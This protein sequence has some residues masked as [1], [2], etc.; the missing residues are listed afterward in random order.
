MDAYDCGNLSQN[1]G[2]HEAQFNEIVRLDCE[3][4]ALINMVEEP[5][6]FKVLYHFKGTIWNEVMYD[7]CF[8]LVL[9]VR[10]SVIPISSIR[11][12]YFVIA[13]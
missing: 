11:N 5:N 8:W 12:E 2:H 6:M 13:G 1:G 10:I 4:A 9:T 3:R 7:F